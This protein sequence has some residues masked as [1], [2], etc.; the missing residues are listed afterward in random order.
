MC[1]KFHGQNPLNGNK[2]SPFF[3]VLFFIL[4]PQLKLRLDVS[5]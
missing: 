5:N 1:I 2:D 3:L 4:K